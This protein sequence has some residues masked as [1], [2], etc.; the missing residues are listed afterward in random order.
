MR[1]ENQWNSIKSYTSH[2]KRLANIRQE[3]MLPKDSDQTLSGNI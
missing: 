2:L 1:R 3:S